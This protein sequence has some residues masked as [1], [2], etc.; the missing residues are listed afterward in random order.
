MMLQNKNMRIILKQGF[1]QK[2]A[3]VHLKICQLAIKTKK[4]ER[5][6]AIKELIVW[7]PLKNQINISH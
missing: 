6:L 5:N 2:Q 7:L 1:I 3:I 4:H